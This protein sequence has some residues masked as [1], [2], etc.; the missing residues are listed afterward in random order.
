MKVRTSFW[1]VIP[2]CGHCVDELSAEIFE[3]SK[4][5]LENRFSNILVDD[6]SPRIRILVKATNGETAV[7]T[8]VDDNVSI[9][10]SEGFFSD[11]HWLRGLEKHD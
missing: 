6:K 8:L 3:N 9:V 11:L 10:G 1:E 7:P 2:T 5:R 4:K